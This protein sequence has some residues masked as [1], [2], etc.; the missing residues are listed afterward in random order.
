MMRFRCT[1]GARDFRL[2]RSRIDSHRGWWERDPSLRASL[3]G[4]IEARAERLRLRSGCSRVMGTW[5]ALL[6]PGGVEYDDAQKTYTVAGSGENMWFAKDAF[7]F[8]LEEGFRRPLAGG[9]RRVPRGRHGQA[10]QGVPDGPA[11]PGRRLGLR[12]CRAPR[13]RPDV[14]PVPRG[15]GRPA[16][17]RCRRMS[18][19]PRRLRLEKRGKYVRCISAPRAGP[20][21]LGR[22]GADRVQGAVLCR[23]R[24]LL[25]Q[26]G[27]DGEGGLLQRGT[28]SPLPAASG[29]PSS[30]AASRPSRSRRPTV[31][32]SSS[33]P[34]GS[35]PPTGCATA[36][37]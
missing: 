14:A 3:N 16:R 1:F 24:R 18:R 17:T 28:A 25:A 20:E 7:H 36:T 29:R 34:A 6:H 27:R 4:F 33:R 31:A 10:S 19:A 23:D 15:Q 11:E 22:G 21:I 35:R 32:S 37:P 12:R 9:R 2:D 5:A 8:R 26:Q 13:R 30:T